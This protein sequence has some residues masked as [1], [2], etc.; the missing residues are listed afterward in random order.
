MAPTLQHV[1]RLGLSFIVDLS[2]EFAGGMF[3]WFGDDWWTL[4]EKALKRVD[5]KPQQFESTVKTD[6]MKIEEVC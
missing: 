2:S 4:K 6:V 3:T 1:H 5:I